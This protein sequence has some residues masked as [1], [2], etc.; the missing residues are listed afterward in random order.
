MQLL[1]GPFLFCYY[2]RYFHFYILQTSFKCLHFALLNHCRTIFLSFIFLLLILLFQVSPLW[3]MI[4]SSLMSH[5]P[6]LSLFALFFDRRASITSLLEHSDAHS[7]V[8]FCQN[9]YFTQNIFFY[10]IKLCQK[11][12]I[13]FLKFN[14]YVKNQFNNSGFI[15]SVKN[16]YIILLA[17]HHCALKVRSC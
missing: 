9:N 15:F 17:V 3:L 7:N 1:A 6:V 8:N 12:P 4:S 16:Y 5:F 11:S 10:K 14:F 13:S 2:F